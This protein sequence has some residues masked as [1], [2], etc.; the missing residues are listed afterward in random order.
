MFVLPAQHPSAILQETG[1]LDHP[2]LGGSGSYQSMSGF[3]EARTAAMISSVYVGGW[4]IATM[5]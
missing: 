3:H 5:N 1:L 4:H 2:T